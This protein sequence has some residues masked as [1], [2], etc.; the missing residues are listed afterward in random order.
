MSEHNLPQQVPLSGIC[1]VLQN[2]QR[3]FF[4]SIQSYLDPHQLMLAIAEYIR[5]SFG[6]DRCAIA[7]FDLSVPGKETTTVQAES[8]ALGAESQ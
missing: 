4:S 2:R 8:L 3:S 5:T 7:T 6:V 1:E